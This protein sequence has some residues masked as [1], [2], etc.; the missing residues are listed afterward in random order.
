MFLYS[1][2]CIFEVSAAF[3]VVYLF[4]YLCGSEVDLSVLFINVFQR[5]E[6]EMCQRIYT[7]I[8]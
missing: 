3:D 7:E 1:Y 6:I 4:M 2:D 8:N 5:S